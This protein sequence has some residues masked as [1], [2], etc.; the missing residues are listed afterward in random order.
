[1]MLRI[2]N[3][4]WSIVI[5]FHIPILLFILFSMHPRETIA[6]SEALLK[7]TAD[8]RYEKLIQCIKLNENDISSC[9][10]EATEYFK[11]EIQYVKAS[12]Q[13]EENSKRLDKMI[14]YLKKSTD[15]F[16]NKA[17]ETHDALHY[18]KASRCAS[19]LVKLS[20][21]YQEYQHCIDLPRCIFSRAKN[22]VLASIYR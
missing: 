20:D 22:L 21:K 17:Q 4:S 16:F 13:Q 18:E 12:E 11:A 6:S 10:N 15:I 1:M 3:Y 19:L 5:K 8:L 14:N 7:G 2:R 9:I